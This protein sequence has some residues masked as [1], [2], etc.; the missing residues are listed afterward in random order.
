MYSNAKAQ[1]LLQ[2]L[3]AKNAAAGRQSRNMRRRFL[4]RA[5]KNPLMQQEFAKKAQQKKKLNPNLHRLHEGVD[6][7]LLQ[8]ALYRDDD[9]LIAGA[10]FGDGVAVGVDIRN[11]RMAA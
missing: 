4:K 8:V 11:S 5:R 2:I 7:A 1:R 6:Q 10:V 9:A 3:T